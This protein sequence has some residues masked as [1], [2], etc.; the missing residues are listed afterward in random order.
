[1]MRNF[2]FSLLVAVLAIAAHPTTAQVTPGA[3]PFGSFGGGAVDV[4]NLA[5]NNVHIAIPVRSRPGRGTDFSY[6]LSYDSSVWFPVGVSGSQSWQPATNW[7]WAGQTQAAVG[8]VS[9]SVTTTQCLLD[10]GPPRQYGTVYW[11]K[12]WV[13]V[14]EF[15]TAH[16]F[17]SF[18][19]Y[20]SDCTNS[21][22]GTAT[23]TDGSGYNL[24]A[25]ALYYP[26]VVNE[27]PRG[28]GIIYPPVQSVN[29]SG[30]KNDSNGNVLSVSASSPQ[31]FTDTLGTT[32]LTITGSVPNPVSY[33]Y[34]NS[35]GTSVS[36][37]IYY[38][39]YTVKTY[40][41]ISG[42]SEYGPLDVP[43][44][45]HVTL[46]NGRQYSFTYEQT[47]SGAGCTPLSGT[48]SNYCV[49]ARIASLTLPTGGQITYG[50][51]GGSNGIFSD[52]SAATLT[53]TT[54]DGTW[55]YARAQGTPPASTTTITAPPLSYDSAANVTVISFQGL[56]E[57]QRLV[58][59]GS[60]P[61]TPLRTTNTCYNGATAPCISTA[62]ALP[63]TQRTVLTQ[64]NSGTLQSKT[65]TFYN[66][67]GLPTEIDEY[68]FGTG[69]PPSTPTRKTLIA[70]AALTSVV[71][72]PASI[73]VCNGTGTSS[74]C[75]G[76]GTLVAYATFGYD[77]TAVTATSGVPQHVSP[78]GSRGNLTTVSRW[79][80]GSTYA[81][82]TTTYYDT[83]NVKVATD[84]GLHTTTFSYTDSWG[85]SACAPP[86]NTQAFAT[87]ITNHLNQNTQLKYYQCTGQAYSARD[88]ND[89][90]NNRDGARFAYSD[91]L[92]RPTEVDF[93]DGGQTSNVYD[94]IVRT[95]TTTHKQSGSVNVSETDQFDQLGR[96]VQR[97]LPASRKVDT[98]YDALGRAWKTSNPYVVAIH[99]E[100]R[101]GSVFAPLGLC[102][103]AARS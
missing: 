52:G 68:D 46:P 74:T 86:A 9:Y 44:V 75:G 97:Q 99:L 83:G 48:Y 72:H 64:P 49:T 62:I 3:P 18:T 77:Q 16:G 27:T 23:A 47:P 98:I 24:F 2:R 76:T 22:N 7:G 55:T 95:I 19:V 89:I 36:A 65:D 13:Y 69:G 101:Q 61:G 6:T 84:P 96:L 21:T 66:A 90:A 41:S 92:D 14:D 31:V 15:G 33:T 37:T 28:G 11:Y 81:T 34:K 4:V 70:Y 57:T 102:C 73:A 32:A 79:I 30:S 78:T 12:N 53:R 8:Y 38:Q 63:I 5:N 103:A 25:N 10:P 80:S 59:Q 87:Q 29:G 20:D 1:M 56:Y 54:P 71:D 45:D 60:P 94:D 58:Y 40:F 35:S 67:Y 85:D 39:A 93:A 17:G 88:P 50:Y 82:S 91:S 26:L 51:S 43:L 42:I 100:R